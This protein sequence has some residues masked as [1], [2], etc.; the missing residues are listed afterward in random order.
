MRD[1][2]L[3]EGVLATEF[4]QDIAT[5]WDGLQRFLN[6]PNFPNRAREFKQELADAI[7][8]HRITPDKFERLTALDQDSQEDVDEFLIEE[9]WN[10]LYPNEP[11]RMPE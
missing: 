7:L 8:N 4:S 11:V 3:L 9:I 2:T 10:Q 1:E 6:H 5:D